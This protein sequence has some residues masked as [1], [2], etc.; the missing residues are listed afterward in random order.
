MPVI[1]LRNDPSNDASQGIIKLINAAAE[2]HK[3]QTDLQKEVMLYQVKGK[4]DR[5]QKQ[6]EQQDQMN[7]WGKMMQGQDN[8]Q[9]NS[10]TPQQQGSVP[11]SP[12]S[13]IGGAMPQGGY[14]PQQPPPMSM[15]DG[16]NQAQVQQMQQQPQTQPQQPNLPPIVKTQL[17]QELGFVPRPVARLNPE[18]GS[19]GPRLVNN[20]DY[21]GNAENYNQILQKNS[22]GIPLTDGEMSLVKTRLGL[23]KSLAVEEKQQQFDQRQWST[24]IQKVNPATASSRSTVGMAANGN[25]RAE[26]AIATI[27]DN[28]V[29]TF[30]DLGNVIG[31]LAG[32]YQGGAPTDMGMKHQQYDSIQTKLANIKQFFSGKP[33][34]AVPPAIK[35]KILNTL[36]GLQSVNNSALTNYLDSVESGQK[37]LISKFS[38]EW[39]NF[40]AD[41]QKEYVRNNAN[42]SSNGNSS[43][44]GNS[45][46]PTAVNQKTGQKLQLSEDGKSWIPM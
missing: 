38:D 21:K 16:S 43:V 22:Q 11:P 18:M 8:V 46:R 17:E 3:S 6:A 9:A 19:E 34:D 4:M 12:I 10:G 36:Y 40:R 24:F 39:Q 37:K 29:M 25:L 26:R 15:A 20:P 1:D 14:T 7:N 45:N 27:K 44:A 23:D 2:A 35:D 13:P 28:P 5:E 33:Q 42:S 32:I 41:I 31:D 30:Q